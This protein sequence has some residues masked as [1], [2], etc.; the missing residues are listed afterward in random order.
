MSRLVVD[1]G[2]DVETAIA[3]LVG[4]IEETP[5][6]S[7]RYASRWL[8]TAL[9][10]EDPGLVEPLTALDGGDRLVATRDRLAEELRGALGERRTLPS[11]QRGSRQRT[12][13]RVPPSSGRPARAATGPIESTRS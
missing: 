3:L 12:R 10:D 11:P 8:A 7:E 13:L 5:D 1:Y 2:S 9:L 6:V 4:E